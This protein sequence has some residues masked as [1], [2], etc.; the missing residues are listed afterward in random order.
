MDDNLRERVE[1]LERAVTDGDHDLSA[2]ADAGEMAE[3]LDAVETR[4]EEF[5][6]RIDELEAATQAL[7]GYVGNIRSVNRDVEQRAD[8]A[9]A[10]VREI[11]DS[12]A[13]QETEVRQPQ[14]G[15]RRRKTNH[16]RVPSTATTDGGVRRQSTTKGK[17][18]AQNGW[19]RDGNG[20]SQR[21]GGEAVQKRRG[22]ANTE[23]GHEARGAAESSRRQSADDGECCEYRCR[24]CGRTKS[25]RAG[26][27]D[28]FQPAD[29][30]F[31]EGSGNE[32]PTAEQFEQIGDDDPLISDGTDDEDSRLQRFRKLL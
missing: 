4:L 9:L 2:L 17:E 27:A 20:Q 26:E 29:S 30:S 21:D 24:S 15:D 7:R 12:I 25:R 14:T 18:S 1:T 6:D 28:T 11:E 5:E 13:G 23:A 3:R 16:N 8:T 22:T 31:E 10:K 19:G 32:H